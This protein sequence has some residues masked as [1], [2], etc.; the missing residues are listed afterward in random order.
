MTD[1]QTP[2][3]SGCEASVPLPDDPVL[4]AALD[5]CIRGT[6]DDD[7]HEE[8]KT[9]L[10]EKSPETPETLLKKIWGYDGFRGIQREIIT[11]VLEGH[12]TLGLM[13]TG[14]GKSIAFQVPAL[15][16]GG[17]CI[18]VTPLI[19]LMRDQV[20][21]LRSKGIKATCVHT[22]MAH[23]DILREYDNCILGHYQFLYLS[24]ERLQSAPFLTKLPR[25]GVGLL[26]I[27]EAH[28]ISQWGYDFRPAYLRIAKLRKLLPGVPVLALTATAT[29]HVAAD[30][31]RQLLFG[32]DGQT[33][34]MSFV[35]QNLAYK[36]ERLGEQSVEDKVGTLLQHLR[37]TEGSTIVYTRNR[38][39]TEELAATLV[40][41]GIPALYYH[42][43]LLAADRHERQKCWIEGRVRVMVATNA[44]GMGID[45]PDVRHVFHIDV[46]ETIEEYYQEAGRAG[47]DGLPAEALLIVDH[48]DAARLLRHCTEEF[49]WKSVIAAIYDDLGSFFQLA[50]GDGENVSY[51]FD[52]YQFC[53]YFKYSLTTVE[54]SLRIL[55]YSGYLEYS[56]DED[57][58]SRLLFIV[59]R[60]SLYHEYSRSQLDDRVMMALL[61]K[62]T[63]LFADYVQIDEK[64]LAEMC[65]CK[66]Q[67]VY[68]ALLSLSRRRIVHY[69]P[70]KHTPTITYVRR[71]V[72][73]RQLFIPPEAYELRMERRQ[74]C[75][76]R[77]IAYFTD[78]SECRSRQL[79]GYFGETDGV[80]DCGICDV[81]L[82]KQGAAP[83]AEASDVA[84]RQ[85]V[86]EILGDGAAHDLA[87]LYVL[88][89]K[90]EEIADV[91]LSLIEQRRATLRGG[92]IVLTRVTPH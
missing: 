68:E 60:D 19:S 70:Q 40:S 13:P 79:V 80:G 33:F 12:D 14:G 21:R 39:Q 22:G 41:Q 50:V 74:Q 75:V 54:A 87:E 67:E 89:Y 69:I 31:R 92:H 65:Q 78:D 25:M 85:R 11:S 36:V 61:R 43:G 3:D 30:I 51:D 53:K 84:L 44:F 5:S 86:L 35:R 9:E 63:G 47:R 10:Q 72:D 4:R 29:P 2:A 49:P 23:A 56:D 66:E 26:T 55:Q 77:M 8:Q 38:K 16:R 64:M 81:C 42:G 37:T 58:H 59:T 28:C 90:R 17:L 71:R 24:P 83:H 1:E 6:D 48:H 27:D 7:D 91:L 52:A 34:R 62:Y 88:P 20:N 57:F 76:E 82:Q 15:L 32:A 73:S 46:P 45:K 18:V